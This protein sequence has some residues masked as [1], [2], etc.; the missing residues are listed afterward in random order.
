MT[1]GSHNDELWFYQQYTICTICG[2]S[3]CQLKIISYVCVCARHPHTITY[4][5]NRIVCLVIWG[6]WRVGIGRHIYNS[7]LNQNISFIFWCCSFSVFRCDFSFLFFFCCVHTLTCTEF[8]SINIH[9]VGI[10]SV[11][12][13]EMSVE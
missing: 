9:A 13:D 7:K 5:L 3:S 4:A 12:N 11:I 2:H 1:I 10:Y 6:C 8:S